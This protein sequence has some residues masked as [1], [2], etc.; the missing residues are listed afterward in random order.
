MRGCCSRRFAKVG[1]QHG[2]APSGRRRSS[3]RS[4]ALAR[5]FGLS[6]FEREL[7]L[8]AAAVELDGEIAALARAAAA[9]ATTR[10]RRS[11]SRS[12]RCRRRTG[13]RS[14]RLRRSGA[15]AWSSP[16]PG[17]RSR[18]AR[19]RST[20][21]SSTTSSASTRLDERLDGVVRAGRP[22]R[23][24]SRRRRTR[25]ADELARPSPAAGPR[26]LVKLDGDDVMPGSASRMRLART[27]GRTPS[28]CARRAAAGRPGARRRRAPRR[29]RGAAHRR[30]AGRR[31]RGAVPAV[32][33]AFL[34]ELEAPLVVLLG[35]G[36]AAPGGRVALHRAVRLPSPAEARAL[37]TASLG[38]PARARRRRVDELAQHFRLGASAIAGR[39][40]G[41]VG[42]AR[43]PT[44]RRCDDSAASGRASGSKASPSASIPPRAGTTSCC[45]TAISSCCTRSS[46]TSATARRSTSAG[47]SPSEP[48]AASA[49]PR[50]SPARA[51]R[52]RRWPPRCSPRELGLDLYRIDL[53]ATVSKYIGETEKNL[54]RLFDAA[55]ASGAV[56]LFDEADALFGKRG[57]VKDGHDRYANLEVAYLL[58]RME[59]YR[60]LAILTTNL[61]SERRPRV[62][63]AA[64]LRRPVPVPGR[65][66]ARRDLAAHL[67]ATRAAR[68]HRRG[69]A[70]AADRVRRLDPLDRALRG[71]RRGRGTERRSRPQHVLRAAQVDY[72]KAERALTDSET[73]GLAMTRA[74]DRH[75]RARRP[76]AAAA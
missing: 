22:R 61:R 55:E 39:C 26:V 21:G 5:L 50:C 24:R 41:A 13:T 64:S 62:P 59:S 8:L 48:P 38:E 29:P 42:A 76:R 36:R 17:R 57:E 23:R 10:G 27:L 11:A 44:R 12:P 45:R 56:L 3:R 34:D 60:G 66:A 33:T 75:R 69:A 52:A 15:G 53:A 9:A 43:A 14:R 4:T 1:G 67:P 51:A 32:V 46:V 40:D 28:S 19:S 65:G 68:R 30:R 71:V 6:A 58:Q 20:S 47:A 72:A 35:E 18:A 31:R 16:A 54:R 25:L 73:D 49:S 63:A 37:W 7:L 2:A 74:G 70:R